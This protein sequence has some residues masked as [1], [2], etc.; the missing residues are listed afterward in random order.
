MYVSV[1]QLAGALKASVVTFSEPFGIG[2]GVDIMTW[3]KRGHD[4]GGATPLR[5]FHA[6]LP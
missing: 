3:A 2:G 4:A 5:C 1:C 6:E